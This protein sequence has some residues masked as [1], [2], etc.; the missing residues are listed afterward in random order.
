MRGQYSQTIKTLR[1]SAKLCETLRYYEEKQKVKIL[2]PFGCAKR[3]FIF[4]TFFSSW[5]PE[6]HRDTMRK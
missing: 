1:N 4:F 5:Y 6:K 3:A 2:S